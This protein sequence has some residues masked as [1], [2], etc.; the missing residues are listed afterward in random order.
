MKHDDTGIK[1]S[2][3]IEVTTTKNVFRNFAYD[4]YNNDIKNAKNDNDLNNKLRDILQNLEINN[5]D[6]FENL[7][8]IGV[9]KWQKNRIN[10]IKENIRKELESLE[11]MDLDQLSSLNSDID[12]ELNDIN[13]WKSTMMTMQFEEDNS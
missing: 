1:K 3:G 5:W 13:M 11:T 2:K 10:Q 8:E 4:F 7:F 9:E 12:K 6:D